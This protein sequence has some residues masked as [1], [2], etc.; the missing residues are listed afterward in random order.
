MAQDQVLIQQVRTIGA[1]VFKIIAL[2]LP[3]ILLTGCSLNETRVKE[4]IRK[5]PKIVF[6]VI[7]ENPEQFIEV[8]NRAAQAAQEK[9]NASQADGLRKQREEDL[10]K[11]KQPVLDPL[12]RL[13]GTNGA[14]IV[15]VEYADFQCSACKMAYDGLRKFKEKYKG[16]VQFYYKNMP[17]DFHEMAYPAAAYYE[18]I[19]LQGNDKALKFYEY[20]FENQ[21]G[22]KEKDF[23]KIAAKK[24]GADVQKVEIDLKSSQVKNTIAW[25]MEEFQRFG[26]TGTP[27]VIL[28]GVA[29]H[30]AQRLEDLEA[31]LK[32]TTSK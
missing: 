21:S 29:L 1:P 27:V 9:R 5:D 15:I 6:D 12:R 20:V 24:I 11:P 8:V 2:S 7:E 25:D 19:K 26:F 4:A 32:L 22:L 16:Q 13:V 18:A 14:K 10:K 23:L 17:L 3:T 30:G 31:V 28:N